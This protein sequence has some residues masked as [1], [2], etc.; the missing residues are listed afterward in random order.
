MLGRSHC[1]TGFCTACTPFGVSR[2]LQRSGASPLIDSDEGGGFVVVAGTR[3]GEG[4]YEG[5][6]L[7]VASTAADPR[8]ARPLQAANFCR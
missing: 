4:S 8:L 5:P 3:S 2:A 6:L 1:L 7:A